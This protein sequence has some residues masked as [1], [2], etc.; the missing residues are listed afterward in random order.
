MSTI[1]NGILWYFYHFASSMRSTLLKSKNHFLNNMNLTGC[2]A[3]TAAEE[4]R[5]AQAMGQK[6]FMVM[7]R[8]LDL[9]KER[10]MR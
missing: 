2:G 10:T 4:A 6:Y 3:K 1:E 7:D 8:L 9:L 5:R